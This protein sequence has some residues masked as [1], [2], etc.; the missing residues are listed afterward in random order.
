MSDMQT[1]VV[2][3]PVLDGLVNRDELARQLSRSTRTIIRFE[4]Q[5]LP[6]HRRGR[7]RFYDIAEVRAW[8]RGEMPPP[9]PKGRPRVA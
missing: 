3:E 5:G 8:L 6:V 4:D 9:R 1:A 2:G 7:P